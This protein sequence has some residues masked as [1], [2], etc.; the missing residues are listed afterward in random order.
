[1][2]SCIL[3]P[4]LVGLGAALIGAWIGRVTRQRDLQILENRLAHEKKIYRSLKTLYDPTLRS[5]N[6]LQS[7][8]AAL[9]TNYLDVRSQLKLLQARYA[10][11]KTQL[12]AE[13]AGLKRPVEIIKKTQEIEDQIK[14]DKDPIDR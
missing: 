13:L 3:I 2:T 7:N 1:M 12:D 9:E 4:L 11:I 8:Y 5:F 6:N 14:T 10:T